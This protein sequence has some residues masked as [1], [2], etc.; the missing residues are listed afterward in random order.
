[1]SKRIKQARLHDEIYLKESRY[2][3]PKDSFKF[4]I[5]ILKKNIDPKKIYDVLDIGCANGELLFQLNKNF[6]N[7]KLSGYEIRKDL[8]AKAK[9]QNSDQIT[10]KCVDINKKFNSNKKFDIILC[11]GVL[12]IFDSLDA[13]KKNINKL[14]KK[15][16]SIFLFGNFN[17]YDYDVMI[18]Y[19]DKNKNKN[20]LQTGW[21][22]WSLK[23]IRSLFKNRKIKLYRF[24]IKKKI[25][26]RT[27]D[28]IR[29]WTFKYKGK[30]H[31]MNG[32]MFIQNQMWIQL[33]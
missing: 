26:P 14:S 25:S 19:V 1:M 24:Y 12:S 13:F 31:F 16:S 15:N 9:K 17:D 33:H 7:L 23:T 22:I 4:L 2:D 5:K 3:N 8:L 20:I 29:S 28:L 32:L 11:S 10:F 18:K 21:N 27:N 30:N 6:K